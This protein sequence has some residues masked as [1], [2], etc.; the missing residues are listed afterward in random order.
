MLKDRIVCSINDVQIQKHL[1]VEKSLTYSKAREIALALESAVQGTKD[2]QNPANDAVHKM[3]DKQ[4]N[5]S[6][7]CF[8][9]G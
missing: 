5:S 7:K 9:C 3:T 8:C 2:I 6:S 1:L 4:S